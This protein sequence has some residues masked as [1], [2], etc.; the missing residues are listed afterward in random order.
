MTWLTNHFLVAMPS[1]AESIFERTVILVC[2]HNEEGALGIV[3]NRTTELCLED[4]IK[5]LDL[6]AIDTPEMKQPVYFGGPVQVYRGLVLHDSTNSWAATI[7]VGS[8]LS[9]TMSKDVLEAISENKGPDLCMPLLGFAGW[10]SEQ[11]EK[12]MANN[13]WLSTPVDNSIIFDT[14]ISERW[15]RAASLVGV[16]IESLSSIA[17]HA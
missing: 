17:G 7:S 14:P 6:E 10:E 2:Q 5:E 11:L 3:V 8:G 16:D 13:V 4:I 1:L 9:L 15:H 12:E